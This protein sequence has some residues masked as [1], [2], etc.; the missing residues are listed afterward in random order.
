MKSTK[1][2][3]LISLLVFLIS[4]ACNKFDYVDTEDDVITMENIVVNTGFDW[5]TSQDITI[6]IQTSDNQNKSISRV[7]VKAYT[8]FPESGGRLMVKGVTDENGY[9]EVKRP[10]SAAN[11]KIVLATEHIGLID[12]VEVSIINSVAE[13]N[14]GGQFIPNKSKGLLPTK[15]TNSIFGFLGT[16]N[17]QGVPDYL[18]P[19]NDVITADFMTDITN[20][21]P[22]GLHVNTHHPEYLLSS[23]QHDLELE[24]EGDVYVTF[25]HEGAG[26]KNVLGFYTYNL[27]SP[28]ATVD[29]IDTIFIIFPNSSFSGSG[30]GLQAGNKVNIGTFPENTGI[31]W[32]LAANGW[33]QSTGT[34]TNG[35]GLYYS[36]RDFNPEPNPNLKQHSVFINDPARDRALLCFEDI[37]RD[38]NG[39]DPYNCDHDF[40]DCIFYV[41][42]DPLPC[43]IL[44]LPLIDYTATDT[45]GDGIPDSFDDY[46]ADGDYAFNNYYPCEADYGTLAYEDLWPAKGDFDFNDL[47]INYNFNQITN[48]ENKIAKINAEFI[49]KANGAGFENGFGFELS[50]NPASVNTVS[51]QNLQE[52]FITLNANNTEA[53][54]SNAVIIAYDN[55]F[56]LL[57]HPGTGIGVNTSPG[58][59]YVTP[60]TF[61][62]II[63]LA[64]PMTSAQIGIPPF[65]PFIIINKNR[66]YEVHLPN[67][68]PTDLAE[69][70]IF[71]TW[72]DNTQTGNGIYYKTVNNLPWAINI[73]APFE[74][75]KE[76]VEIA[77]T[78]LKFVDW[79]QS[80]GALYPDWYGDNSGYRNESNIYDIP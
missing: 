27:G 11:D 53:G 16:Y 34:V 28:P 68:T 66:D 9:Y 79:A 51:G 5:K 30:G 22:S 4:T 44:D 33:N 74:Y 72:D 40:N 48:G 25:V 39:S 69:T 63:D 7:I 70:S 12:F 47:V 29:D 78:Y 36:E 45:D 56:N 2:I 8:D 58:A 20:T 14:F 38:N 80:D 76:K 32:V 41:T 62:I 31:G 18:E 60:D 15:S 43:M 17:S 73:W 6:K 75:P 37:R 42:V 61:N 21:L 46:P 67:H 49:A 65:N 52:G 3:L 71:G 19:V 54:Q 64:S 23:Y 1:I 50:T 55:A 26:Y 57:P 59:T 10:V 35:Y 77:A 24:C 13:Y